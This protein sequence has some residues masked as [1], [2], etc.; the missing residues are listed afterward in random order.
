MNPHVFLISVNEGCER[1]VNV[2]VSA[3]IIINVAVSAN[4]ISSRRWSRA[5]TRAISKALPDVDQSLRHAQRPRA[6]HQAREHVLADLA[7]HAQEAGQDFTRLF[8]GYNLSL[9]VLFC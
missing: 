9:L 8:R 2:A 3:N 4:T 5:S 6:H 7:P 1:I